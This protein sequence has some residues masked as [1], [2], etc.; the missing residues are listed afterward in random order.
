MKKNKERNLEQDFTLVDAT[1]MCR[2]LNDS[3]HWLRP[4]LRNTDTN[5]EMTAARPK[6]DAV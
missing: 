6:L 3:Q 4:V 1:V 2:Q 5:F